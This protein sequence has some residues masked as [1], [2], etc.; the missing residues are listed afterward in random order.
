MKAMR[1]ILIFAA[2]VLLAGCSYSP[3][4]LKI[5]GVFDGDYYR[6]TGMAVAPFTDG[7]SDDERDLVFDPDV[8]AAGELLITG[9]SERMAARDYSYTY[10]GED[11]PNAPF[12]R[13]T[14]DD[15]SLVTKIYDNHVRASVR[16]EESDS[17]TANFTGGNGTEL[18]EWAFLSSE[19]ELS[20]RSRF[21]DINNEEGVVEDVLTKT[22][23]AETDDA[24]YFSIGNKH[25]ALGFK[26]L[27]DSGAGRLFSGVI[28]SGERT[29]YYYLSSAP[30]EID[31]RNDRKVVSRIEWMYELRFTNYT[32]EDETSGY[33]L[34]YYR[35]F[36]ARKI[37]SERFR[38]G[39]DVKFLAQPVD[40]MLYEDTW[41][42]GIEDN[43]DYELTDIPEVP[44]P[45]PAEGEGA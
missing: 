33:Y 40:L 24:T 29:F 41:V 22:Y 27:L 44:A 15:V 17:R 37:L 21:F 13:D 23:E 28:E 8:L 16:K 34:S 1:K 5:P 26:L 10:L 4:Q 11:D 12:G 36:M 43:E 20:V 30:F 7:M 45:A 9:S 38:A 35:T 31:L 39:E 14:L 42:Y 3:A 2:G 18:D 25:H 19:T 32:D 6:F